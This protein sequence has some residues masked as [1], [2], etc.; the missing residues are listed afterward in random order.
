MPEDSSQT[1]KLFTNSVRAQFY[2]Q[3]KATKH[4]LACM[5]TCEKTTQTCN[6]SMKENNCGLLLSLKQSAVAGYQE[7]IMHTKAL[8][9][10]GTRGCKTDPAA[11]QLVKCSLIAR[12]IPSLLRL[13]HFQRGALQGKLGNAYFS[14]SGIYT[15]TAMNLFC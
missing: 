7:N 8:E 12:R 6:S 13:T 1:P 4:T 11:A 5:K 9:L 14:L 15:G 3:A 10:V 2:Q